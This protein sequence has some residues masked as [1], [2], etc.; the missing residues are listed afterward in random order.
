MLLRKRSEILCHEPGA[1]QQASGE[2]NKQ[3]RATE[4]GLLV[5]SRE[6]ADTVERDFSFWL[7]LL[8]GAGGFFRVHY[9]GRVGG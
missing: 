6:E 5:T 2:K 8:H 9:L 3:K 1:A 7:F 4:K